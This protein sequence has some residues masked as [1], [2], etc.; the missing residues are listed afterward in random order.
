[1][2]KSFFIIA[3]L[4]IIG[5]G[6]AHAQQLYADKAVNFQSTYLAL[7]NQYDNI[8][9]KMIRQIPCLTSR[10]PIINKSQSYLM[11]GTGLALTSAGAALLVN[12]S[13]RFKTYENT[14]YIFDPA[15]N[16]F[17]N[18]A[19]PREAYFN[20]IKRTRTRSHILGIIGIAT[21]SFGIYGIVIHRKDAKRTSDVLENTQGNNISTPPPASVVISSDIFVHP[22]TTQFVPQLKLTYN[23]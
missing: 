1:M 17:Q 18:E 7:A 6:N 23:F 2:K 4:L 16:D 3:L 19:N 14:P 12:S 8:E 20:S 22:I 9:H 11:T 5:Y 13:K 10:K 15:Y 21:T